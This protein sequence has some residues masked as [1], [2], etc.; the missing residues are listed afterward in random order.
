M[1]DIGTPESCLVCGDNPNEV[2]EM[3]SRLRRQ[4]IHAFG[5][6]PEPTFCPEVIKL[7]P[8]ADFPFSDNIFECVVVLSHFREDEIARVCHSHAFVLKSVKMTRTND[9]YHPNTTDADEFT[10]YNRWSFIAKKAPIVTAFPHPDEACFAVFSWGYSKRTID[11]KRKN[12]SMAILMRKLAKDMP[13]FCFVSSTEPYDTMWEDEGVV[14]ETLSDIADFPFRI[15]HLAQDLLNRKYNRMLYFGNG[16]M[17]C[18]IFVAKR[19]DDV[20]I[21]RFVSK[22]HYC[23]GE[24]VVPRD[25]FDITI[26]HHEYQVEMAQR[27]LPQHK[28][29]L[30]LHVPDPTRYKPLPEVRWDVHWDVL[31][32]GRFDDNKRI[33]ILQRACDI[34]GLKLLVASGQIPQHDIPAYMNEAK[35]FCLP[36][37]SEGGNRSL[38]EAMAC[39]TPVVVCNDSQ[40][41]M[42]MV[43]R[44]GGFSAPPD[45]ESIA[46]ALKEAIKTKPATSQELIKQRIT[47]SGKYDR[48]KFVTTSIGMGQEQIGPAMHLIHRQRTRRAYIRKQ[49]QQPVI[50]QEN[51][52]QPKK[53]IMFAPSAISRETFTT[54]SLLA[55]KYGKHVQMVLPSKC[56]QIDL[57][58]IRISGI[59]VSKGSDDEFACVIGTGCHVNCRT[60]ISEYLPPDRIIEEIDRCLA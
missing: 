31:T 40:S 24:R 51:M 2:A 60:V 25:R 41:N 56:T 46:V 55:D 50:R 32:V 19:L 54:C 39:N 52:K 33:P 23:H 15:K 27:L 44:F 6:C 16:P 28:F 37:K 4:Y 13:V 14:Y 20:G 11:W 45:P 29:A 18:D 10:R 34:A 57:K 5:V 9:Y 12:D 3:V 1:Q 48:F 35:V 59:T 7:H 17:E 58:S 30:L 21:S 36:S 38:L 43:E 26:L 49:N 42:Q 22:A 8:K 53:N 47:P